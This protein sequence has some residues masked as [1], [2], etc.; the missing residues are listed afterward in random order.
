MKKRNYFE[1]L[2]LSLDPLETNVD[3]ALARLKQCTAEWSSAPQ[4]DVLR[5]T[6]MEAVPEMEKVLSNPQSLQKQAEEAL[7]NEQ[8][9]VR[10]F[11]QNAAVDGQISRVI[12]RNICNNVQLEIDSV[13]SLADELGI[14]ISSQAVDKSCKALRVPPQPANGHPVYLISASRDIQKLKCCLEAA[15]K[16]SI[17]EYLNC[18][19]SL[20]P[21]QLLKINSDKSREP[22]KGGSANNPINTIKVEI[23][24]I[25]AKYFKNEESK[26]RYD[27]A[28]RG[29]EICERVFAAFPNYVEGSPGTISPIYYT[30]LYDTLCAEGLDAAD[31]QWLVYRRCCQGKDKVPFPWQEQFT[32]CSKCKSRN[33]AN[34][35]RCSQCGEL[36]RIMCP[37]CGK[38]I[39]ASS[40]QCR[41]CGT[42][43]DAA[44]KVYE[45]LEKCGNSLKGSSE[46]LDTAQKEIQGILRTYP[47]YV[48]A[49]ALLDELGKART[50][51]LL[52]TLEP[53]V[54]KSVRA[55]G[56]E[57]E[58]VWLKARHQGNEL[59]R[60]PDANGTPINYM[61]RRKR[62]G[63]PV[64]PDDG[65]EL[66]GGAASPC[67][68]KL[69]KP[70]VEYGYAVFAVVN[71]RILKGL[72]GG[73]GMVL[74]EADFH[75]S[76]GDGSARLTWCALPEG[77]SA[78]LIRRE[79]GEPES[80]NDGTRL[81]VDGGSNSFHDTGLT[82]G[83]EYGYLLVLYGSGH[84][85]TAHGSGT[86]QLPPPRLE[87]D[88]W[89]YKCLG[90]D[91][92][93]H[94]ELPSGADEVRWMVS[95]KVPITPGS[96]VTANRFK[97]VG[98][99]DKDAQVT[100]LREINLC[101]KFLIPLVI[102]GDTALICT[103]RH[104][105]L[106]NLRLR[107]NPGRIYLQWTWPEG[108]SEVT[109]VYGNKSFVENP[110][111]LNANEIRTSKRNGS[112]QAHELIIPV[113]EDKDYYFSV[114]MQVGHTSSSSWS[115]PRNV[116]SP[117]PGGGNRVNCR[118]AK[119][120]QGWVF[121]VKSKKGIPAM[122]VRC[123]RRVF[124]LS[125]Q[126]GKK[127]L[128]VEASG[129][130]RA[131]V[132]I[133][134]NMVATGNCFMPFVSEDSHYDLIFNRKSLSIE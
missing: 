71:K 27:Y 91:I 119:R 112:E 35:S 132:S 107:R 85:L 78:T 26:K 79:G 89:N 128:A 42:Y 34:S 101:G 65:E 51:K 8:K 115:A 19:N 84:E 50:A 28:W 14:V 118:I 31:A 13:S 2:N 66:G 43:F 47:D 129:Q 134:D 126:D 133:P 25:G 15:G 45:S 96:I 108:C 37:K 81:P 103:G 95:D 70:G 93:I 90:T 20:S 121:E 120:G 40:P 97:T 49:R 60:L 64:S 88:Q 1:I 69:A 36:F 63:I 22:N 10:N 57:L 125:R 67:T 72:A 105:G 106:Q 30:R 123:A 24:T 17:Y 116:Y 114:F 59:D 12:F 3:N 110:D 46:E 80:I 5:K 130:S 23:T 62:N 94:W 33:E 124:P 32:E 77:W 4:D 29:Q 131:S 52:D 9:R 39:H 127:A 21:E 18:K 87:L 117:A 54:I 104:G 99:T 113:M 109:I 102:K 111:D 16:A 11:L 98:E 7:K 76:M 61:L 53:P 74:P 55:S 82:N 92:R 86:P 6:W 73:K 58:I 41:Q 122:E 100:I 56:K 48:P 38:P 75:V 44:R 68:D 83:R